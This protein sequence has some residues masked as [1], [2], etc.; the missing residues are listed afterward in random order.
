MIRRCFAEWW[1]PGSIWVSVGIETPSDESLKETQKLQNTKRSLIGSV[2]EIQNAG[3]LV[4]GGF[5]IG[6]DS[7]TEDI[8]DRQIEFITEAAIPVAMVGT[9]RGPARN[10]LVPAPAGWQV[11]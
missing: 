7:D 8:F 1:R 10:A 5:I 6:F 2:H 4:Y 3:L 9:A 11:G